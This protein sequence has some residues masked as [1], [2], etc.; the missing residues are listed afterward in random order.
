MKSGGGILFNIVQAAEQLAQ[1]GIQARVL[2][3]PTLK[4]L[5]T[6]AVLKAARETSAIITIEEHSIIGGLGSAVAEVL[7]KMRCGDI[8]LRMLGLPDA[9]CKETG[10]QEYLRHVSGLSIEGICTA[11][12]QFYKSLRKKPHDAN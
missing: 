6:D 3:M 9:F 11:T 5:D 1:E 8:P 12:R 7:T 2:S 4:P 10:G